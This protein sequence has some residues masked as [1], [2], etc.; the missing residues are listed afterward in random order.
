M[1]SSSRWPP[2]TLALPPLAQARRVVATCPELL[3]TALPTPDTEED[4]ASLDIGRG[5]SHHRE[6]PLPRRV[7]V[8][9]AT[10]YCCRRR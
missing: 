6:L 9:A 5:L 4:G 7:V 10:S 2:P 8:F 1:T 3:P